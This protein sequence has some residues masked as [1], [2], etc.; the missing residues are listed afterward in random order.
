M[1]TPRLPAVDWTDAPADL[2]G[3]VRF[4]ERRN[5]VSALVPSHFKLSLL[6]N[7]PDTALQDQK[8]RLACW[9]IW[10]YQM[11]Q[12]LTQKQLKKKKLS[13]YKDLE[14]EVSRDVES[15]DKNCASCNWSIRNNWEG[16]RSEPSVAPRSPVGHRAI[17]DRTNEH[18]TQHW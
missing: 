13:K 2:N 9:S 10:S 8:R 18:C 6:A 4:A 11:I 12:T 17:E 7:R 5:L 3:L 1:R 16:I 14:I 15:E